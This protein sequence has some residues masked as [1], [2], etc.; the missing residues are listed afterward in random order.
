[1]MK[2][3]RLATAFWKKHFPDVIE[4]V[5]RAEFEYAPQPPEEYLNDRT[6]F[7]AYFEY[8]AKDSGRG[9]IGVEVKFTEAFSQ[10]VYDTPHYRRLSETP[11]SPWMRESWDLLSDIRWNQLWRDHLLAYSIVKHKHSQFSHACLVLVRHPGD[12][13]C[14][15]T[16]NM[17]RSLL[18]PDDKTFSDMPLDKMLSV[19]DEI[20]AGDDVKAWLKRFR[21]RYM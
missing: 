6:A 1:M 16:V 18:R 11:G 13:E 2:D 7:D 5:I 8:I 19:F 9:V 14:E 3:L 4:Q 21:E 17:Y 10:K 15:K 12:A 20:D